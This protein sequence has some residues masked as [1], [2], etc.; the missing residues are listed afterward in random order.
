MRGLV[1]LTAGH[2]EG[3]YWRE[4]YRQ[5]VWVHTRIIPFFEDPGYHELLMTMGEW[6]A[7]VETLRRQGIGPA[8]ADWLPADARQRALVLTGLPPSG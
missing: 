1:R 4:Q 7:M 5:M 8:P 6:P 3:P 2:P